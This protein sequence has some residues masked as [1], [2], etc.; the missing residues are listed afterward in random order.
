ME[1]AEN[2]I[3]AFVK[4]K[5]MHSVTPFLERKS[6][7][8]MQ[9][10]NV[11]DALDVA[12]ENDYTKIMVFR[13]DCVFDAKFFV[14]FHKILNMINED[15]HGEIFY[16]GSENIGPTFSKKYKDVCV[17]LCTLNMTQH[18]FALRN[19]GIAKMKKA[20]I[21]SN[22]IKNCFNI[23]RLMEQRSILPS[24][25]SKETMSTMGK[26]MQLP[27][28]NLALAKKVKCQS[29][30]QEILERDWQS[31]LAAVVLTIVFNQLKEYILT[32]VA[33]NVM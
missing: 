16:L 26:M 31:M 29:D 2:L 32:K 3:I 27:L 25:V 12:L 33:H 20:S 19:S 14:L 18:A 7:E 24:V 13:D 30:V 9:R 1:G 21:D 11:N 28:V 8:Y 22:T 23:C 5:N 4:C 17:T 15:K 10:D 6:I